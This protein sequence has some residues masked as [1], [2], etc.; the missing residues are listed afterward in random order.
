[1]Q[2][3]LKILGISFNP[4]SDIVCVQHLKYCNNVC[5]RLITSLTNPSLKN[6]NSCY[7]VRNYDLILSDSFQP[8]FIMQL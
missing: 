7:K 3:L 1:M 4:N 8:Y 5:H 6:Q 2:Y